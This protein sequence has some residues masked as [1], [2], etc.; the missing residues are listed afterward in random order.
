MNA[1][2]ERLDQAADRQ[3]R[4]ISD[5][6]HE[7]QSPLTSLRA[8]FE[9]DL[10]SCGDPGWRQSE[11]EALEE[12][13]EMQRLIDDLLTLA[14]FDAR[15]EVQAHEPVDLDDVVLRE[16][17]RLRTRGRVDVD[18]SGVSVGVV[19]GDRDQLRRALRN[20]LDNAERHAAGRVSVAVRETGGEVEV[21]VADDGA[22]VPVEHRDRIFERFARIDDARTRADASTGLG[23][24]ITR[25]IAEAHGGHICVE[26]GPPGACFVLRL[27][28]GGADRLPPARP[29]GAPSASRPE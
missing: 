15:V 17:D 12:I 13:T 6:S 21:R 5:A 7:L 16:A 10:A 22:G 24:A 3:R 14:R 23:L 18:T 8:R 27:P 28:A 1:M 2:L 19:V 11:T 26:T 20:M 29:R 4:F 9:V 25:E